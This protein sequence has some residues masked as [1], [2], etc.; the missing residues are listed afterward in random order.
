[1]YRQLVQWIHGLK[2]LTELLHRWKVSFVD[3]KP[4]EDGPSSA[5]AGTVID[6][7]GPHEAVLSLFFKTFESRNLRNG[8]PVGDAS[9]V[10]Q[11]EF[12]VFGRLLLHSLHLDR[13]TGVFVAPPV[14]LAAL[15]KL[16]ADATDWGDKS[17]EKLAF[18]FSPHLQLEQHKLWFR[19]WDTFSGDLLN[20]YLG[21]SEDDRPDFSGRTALVGEYSLPGDGALVLRGEYMRL[22]KD[23]EDWFSLLCLHR[24]FF[25]PKRTPLLEA[26]GSG[27]A[28]APQ[29]KAALAG[30]PAIQVRTV[31]S[32]TLA[33]EV[34][35]APSALADRHRV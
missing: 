16:S 24:I 11:K 26:L 19:A 2:K 12:E 23:N 17:I 33:P 21:W 25:H 4:V 29:A 18:E 14:Y 5:D 15:G 34:I 8:V 22:T 31:G 32:F 7:G 1:V 3:E 35:S 10:Q 6:D 27:F 30:M 9:E 28:F 20:N 13:P